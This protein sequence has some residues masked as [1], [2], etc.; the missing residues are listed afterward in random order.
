MSLSHWLCTNRLGQD[1]GWISNE[2][3]KL[4]ATLLCSA[5]TAEEE[6]QEA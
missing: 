4:L 1:N 3:K 5:K 6:Q 2:Q